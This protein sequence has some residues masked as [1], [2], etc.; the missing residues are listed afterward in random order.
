[1][2]MSFI[3]ISLKI[4]EMYLPANGLQTVDLFMRK[5]GMYTKEDL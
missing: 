3:G 4:W 5:F 2:N 1:M